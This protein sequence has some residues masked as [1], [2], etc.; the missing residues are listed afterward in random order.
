MGTLLSHPSPG[1]S[2]G[3]VVL[4]DGTVHEFER[5]IPAAELMLDHPRQVV[6]EVQLISGGSGSSAELTRPLPADHVLNPEKVYAMLPMAR[7]KA[8]ALSAEEVR[9]ILASL[10]G[11]PRR[12][13]MKDVVLT[14]NEA[15]GRREWPV[16]EFLMRQHSSKRWKPS[17]LAIEEGHPM[18]KLP[19]WLF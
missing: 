7:K 14:A 13:D 5:P 18:R 17:L 6:A 1:A 11:T 4:S 12:S 3:R 9:R 8:G 15:V 16:P 10:G 2:G 19:H